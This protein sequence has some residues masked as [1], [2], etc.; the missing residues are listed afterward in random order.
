MSMRGVCILALFAVACVGPPGPPGEEGPRGTV[1]SPGNNGAPGPAGPPGSGL[2]MTVGCSGQATIGTGTFLLRHE[3]YRFADGSVLA[4]C[5]VGGANLTIKGVN[6]WATGTTGA[7]VGGCLVGVDVDTASYGFFSMELASN[8]A[9]TATYR[10][11]S[12]TNNGRTFPL[13]CMV[14]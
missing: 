10:D 14:R 7:T 9:S 11:Q 3:S 4:T 12:S 1:G 6:M 5:E 13:T 8:A 2:V